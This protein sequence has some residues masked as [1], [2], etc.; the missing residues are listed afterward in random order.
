MSKGAASIGI[1]GGADGP[2]S[3]FI[4]GKQKPKL[5]ERIRRALYMRKRRRVEAGIASAPHT[6]EEVVV[7]IQ[8]KYRGMEVSKESFDY[9][10]QKR[11][12][13][14]SLIFE[15]RPELGSKRADE[16]SDEEFPMDFHIYEIVV[17]EKGSLQ[18]C[19]ETVWER[20]G[21][22]YS[23]D[24]KKMKHLGKIARDLY[25]YYGV[26]EEDIRSRS[27]RFSVL[28]AALCQ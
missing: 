25:S 20:F 14:E 6:L 13:R 9:Q 22:S 24:K 8:E 27:V 1:I 16:V 7:Y 21:V 26:T 4:A 3:V 5:R 2:T 19:I 15:H 11:C 28:A 10:E 23:G 18:V 12:L 17:Q